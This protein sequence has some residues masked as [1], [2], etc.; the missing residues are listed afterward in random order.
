MQFDS[1]SDLIQMSGHGVYVWAVYFIGIAVLV[2]NVLRPKMMMKQ[3]YQEQQSALSLHAAV[4]KE[5]LG[6]ETPGETL[7]SGDHSGK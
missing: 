7:D 2:F 1:L 4:T 3:F 5:K 6:E